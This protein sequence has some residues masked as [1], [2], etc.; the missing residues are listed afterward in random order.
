LN[1]PFNSPVKT[2]RKTYVML[3]P[4]KPYLS[5]NYI[6]S[7]FTKAATLTPNKIPFFQAGLGEICF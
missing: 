5:L 4:L 1:F 6:T 7:L 3:K 2:G